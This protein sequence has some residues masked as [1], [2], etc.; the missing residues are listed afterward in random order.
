MLDKDDDEDGCL[1]ASEVKS[2]TE[3]QRSTGE[4]GNSVGKDSTDPNLVGFQSGRKVKALV[5][6]SILTKTMTSSG[7]GGV[8]GE[9]TDE[10]GE[11][12]EGNSDK[13]DGKS[14]VTL[15][16]LRLVNWCCSG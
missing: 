12:V 10:E 1:G 3:I 14:L 8:N 13:Q 9:I 4:V 16:N 5:T 11:R 7:S 6:L 2:V 15:P